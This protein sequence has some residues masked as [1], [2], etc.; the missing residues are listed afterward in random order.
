MHNKN[1]VLSATRQFIKYIQTQW[2]TQIKGWMLNTVGEYKSHAFNEMLC[3]EGIH[4]Y[5]SAPHTPQQNSRAERHIHTLMD[6]AQVMC[7]H[8]CLP[9]SYWEFAVNQAVHIHNRVS[10]QCLNWKMPM[11]FLTG[12]KPDISHLHTFGCCAYVH[13]SQE[14]HGRK[15]QP[16]SQLM[17]HISRCCT[18]KQC[19]YDFHEAGQLSLHPITCHLQ[20]A[21]FPQVSWIETP[22]PNLA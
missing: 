13:L 9:P 1:E 14:Q 8:T 5:Q 21:L 11:E 17:I 18:Y 4:I 20:W 10:S 22:S 12:Q 19:Q 3:N 2:N 7:L 6:K 15:L 16:K